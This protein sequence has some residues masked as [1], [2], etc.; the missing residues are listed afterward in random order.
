MVN[1]AEQKGK[2]III[3]C[4]GNYFGRL[5]NVSNIKLFGRP[6]EKEESVITK[7]E[8]EEWEKK[9]WNTHKRTFI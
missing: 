3:K 7:G 4:I 8:R 2:K 9:G 1:G 5:K 6:T